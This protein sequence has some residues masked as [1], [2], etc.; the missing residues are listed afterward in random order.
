MTNERREY[1]A[2]LI[3]NS[4]SQ[5]DIEYIES[6]HLMRILGELN[7]IEIIWLRFYL[8]PTMGGDEEF[9]NK[10]AAILAPVMATMVDPPSVL[11]KESLQKNYKEHLSQQGLLRPRYEVD[12]KTHLPEY[13]NFTGN[14]KIRG[15]EITSLGRFLLRQIG[16]SDPV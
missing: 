3:T 1:I 12:T 13:D 11:E 7:D 2:N 5:Q 14:Q 15:Y 9:R 4:L 16:L 10:H 6:K 8:H